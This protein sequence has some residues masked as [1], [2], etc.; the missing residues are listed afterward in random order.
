MAKR[1]VPD[2]EVARFRHCYWQECRALFSICVHCDR[3]QRYCSGA[4]RSAARKQQRAKA[5][6]RHQSGPSGKQAHRDC[7]R[8]YRDRQRSAPVT[9]PAM[10]KVNET[11]QKPAA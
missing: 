11:A 7:Q 4:C 1:V 8:R 10:N 6:A 5:N 3:G 2:S 9:D